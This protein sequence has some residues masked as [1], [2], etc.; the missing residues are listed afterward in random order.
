MVRTSIS[1]FKQQQRIHLNDFAGLSTVAEN[2]AYTN[3]AWG[4][5]RESYTPAKRGNLVVVTL[6]S[7][8]NATHTRSRAYRASSRPPAWRP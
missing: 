4:D 3:L 2:T 5:R 7:I 8:V 6:E 1:D